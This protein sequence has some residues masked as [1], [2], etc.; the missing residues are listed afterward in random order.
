MEKRKERLA[1]DNSHAPDLSPDGT[2]VLYTTTSFREASERRRSGSDFEL[3]IANLEGKERE[4][5]GE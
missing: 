1:Y 5:C 4:T 3:A 2:A